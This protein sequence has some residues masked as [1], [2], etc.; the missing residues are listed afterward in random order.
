[1]SLQTGTKHR[2]GS[3]ELPRSSSP[4]VKAHELLFAHFERP[5]L[6]KVW[7]YLRDFGL[8]RAKKSENELFMRGT[9]QKPYIYRVTRGPRARFLGLGL[10]VSKAEHLE[11]LSRAFDGRVERADGLGSGFVVRLRDPQGVAVDVLYGMTPS[12]PLPIRHNVPSNIIRVKT[13]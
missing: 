6:D 9:G 7:A 11:T 3:I 13:I 12:A 10:S 1:M 5:D 2:P 4:L 8:V